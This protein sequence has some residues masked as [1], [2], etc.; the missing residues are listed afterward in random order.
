MPWLRAYRRWVLARQ[1]RFTAQHLVPYFFD[2]LTDRKSV[3]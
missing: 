1:Y 3:V 2:A